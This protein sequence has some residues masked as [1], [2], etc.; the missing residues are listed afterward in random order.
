[1][2]KDEDENFSMKFNSK[3]MIINGNKVPDDL[4]KK[5]KEIYKK[6]YGKDIDDEFDINNNYDDE[7]DS[8]DK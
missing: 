5:Y 8:H 2:I 7:P 1:M 3:E 4:F 6:H